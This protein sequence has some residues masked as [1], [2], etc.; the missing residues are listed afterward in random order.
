[1]RKYNHLLT[2]AVV[3]RASRGERQGGEAESKRET[4]ANPMRTVPKSVTRQST[5]QRCARIGSSL[6]DNSVAMAT[7]VNLHMVITRCT[8]LLCHFIPSISLRIVL[9]FTMKCRSHA[10]MGS[11]VSSCTRNAYL[12]KFINCTMSTSSIR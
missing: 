8:Y 5:R 10:H 2:Q 6:M 4:R 9:S 12:K 3:T 11:A 1:M 7:S